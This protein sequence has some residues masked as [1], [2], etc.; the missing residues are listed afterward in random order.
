MGDIPP[1]A[2]AA[3][4]AAGLPSVAVANFTWDWV[5]EDYEPE[6]FG[7]PDLVIEIVSKNDRADDLLLKVTQYLAAGTKA[8]WLLYPNTRLAYRYSAGKLEPE[9]RSAQAG[10]SF[11]EPALLPGFS[12]PLNEILFVHNQHVRPQLVRIHCLLRH[13][14]GLSFHFQR[15]THPGEQARQYLSLGIG[16][17]P[18]ENQGPGGGVQAGRHERMSWPE[19]RFIGG[20]A[21]LEERFGLR[22]LAHV[23]IQ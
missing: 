11:E 1:L 17:D 3:A 18:A 2:F 20:Q 14:K 13:Y 10:Q 8:V 9:V 23:P 19:S 21:A 4:H 15:H 12:I 7:A 5:Y 22:I 16:Q 6:R